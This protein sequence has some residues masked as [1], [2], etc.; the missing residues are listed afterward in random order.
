MEEIQKKFFTSSFAKKNP[1]RKK[2]R[3]HF[4]PKT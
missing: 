1:G 3:H 2:I 4:Q